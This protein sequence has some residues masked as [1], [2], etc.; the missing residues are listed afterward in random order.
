MKGKTDKRSTRK[1]R[2][3]KT[4]CISLWPA[5][6]LFFFSIASRTL[7]YSSPELT[8]TTKKSFPLNDPRNPD[9]PCHKYQKIADDEYRE[10]QKKEKKEEQKR[11]PIKEETARKETAHPTGSAGPDNAE[12]RKRSEN[13]NSKKQQH[14]KRFYKAKSAWSKKF[15]KGFRSKKD[16]SS[17][18]HWK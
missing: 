5:L 9:C 6:F 17:C 2:T 10:M 13:I 15:S 14:G 1:Y 7:A 4:F 3:D 12:K 18:F 8:D 11:E 16:P